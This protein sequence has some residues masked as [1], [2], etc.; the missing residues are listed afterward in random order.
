VGHVALQF[1]D[2]SA[3]LDAFLSAL[4]NQVKRIIRQPDQLVH[5]DEKQRMELR[6]WLDAYIDE[7]I[8]LKLKE[9]RLIKPS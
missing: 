8:E 6:T 5:G 9:L 7:R 3:T 4:D 2:M 1:V